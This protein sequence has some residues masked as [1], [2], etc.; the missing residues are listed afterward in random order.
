[1]NLKRLLEFSNLVTVCYT[2]HT[3]YSQ[4]LYLSPWD[5]IRRMSRESDCGFWQEIIFSESLAIFIGQW[6]IFNDFYQNES[7]DESWF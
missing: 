6:L 3:T 2:G 4:N 5:R 7:S 1:M